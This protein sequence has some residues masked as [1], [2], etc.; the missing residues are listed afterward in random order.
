MQKLLQVLGPRKLEDDKGL[1]RR[2]RNVVL[3][4]HEGS[5]GRSS[6]ARHSPLSRH[7]PV[8]GT[9]D[10]CDYR[11]PEGQRG[12][13]LLLPCSVPAPDGRRVRFVAGEGP[14]VGVGSGALSRVPTVLVPGV[15]CRYLYEEP[16]PLRGVQVV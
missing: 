10:R 16:V 12:K 2:H 15:L 5:P 13:R 11:V 8:V 14:S 3:V 1:V 4:A 9:G 6:A 7:R